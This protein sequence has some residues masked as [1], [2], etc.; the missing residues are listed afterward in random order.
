MVF[1]A[2]RLRVTHGLARSHEGREGGS[3]YINTIAVD[4]LKSRMLLNEPYLFFGLVQILFGVACELLSQIIK[5]HWK[6]E[7][8]FIDELDIYPA[9]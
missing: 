8:Q 5:G 1:A 3:V 2:S 6:R 4:Y 9:R 7:L